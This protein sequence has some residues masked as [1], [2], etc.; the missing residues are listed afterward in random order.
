[1]I[2][3]YTNLLLLCVKIADISILVATE[4]LY[5]SVS[6][7]LN[8]K[9]EALSNGRVYVGEIFAFANLVTSSGPKAYSVNS[10][11]LPL[12]NLVNPPLIWAA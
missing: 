8:T 6:V 12:F 3:L 7:V 4:P 11:A 9:C 10:L 2:A 5:K 1:M